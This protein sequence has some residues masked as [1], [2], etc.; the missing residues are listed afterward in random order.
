MKK[1]LIFPL[2]CA[3]FCFAQEV[4]DIGKIALSVVIP[5]II[6]ELDASQKSK[7]EAKITQIT[8]ASGLAATGY[9]QSFV[10]YPRF[11]IYQTDVVETGMQNLTKVTAELSLYIKQTMTNTLFASTSRQLVGTGKTKSAAITDAIGKLP[12]KDT[13]LTAFIET[14]RKKIVQYYE[15]KCGDI[16]AKA[17]GLV[18]RQEYSGAIFELLAVPEECS[19]CYAKVSAKA[20]EAF[21]AYQDK[22]CKEQMQIAKTKVAGKDFYGALRALENINTSA[23]CYGEATSLLASITE[24]IDAEEKQE[25][26]L[27]MQLYN[28]AKALEQRNFEAAQKQRDASNQLAAQAIQAAKQVGIAKAKNQPQ[29]IIKNVTWW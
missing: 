26:D 18:K 2:I 28:D 15:S 12:T 22:I 11:T 16:I 7:L 17:D 19:S 23:K 8:V 20:V 3:A 4:S 27:Q 29:P 10:I 13:E 5:D 9:D 14:G 25:W 6:E 24:K 1:T 21:Y